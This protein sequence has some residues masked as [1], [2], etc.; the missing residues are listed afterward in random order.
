MA[1]CPGSDA[2]RPQASWQNAQ[3]EPNRENGS[4]FNFPRND[5]NVTR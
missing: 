4:V 1:P 5:F 2:G 3:S